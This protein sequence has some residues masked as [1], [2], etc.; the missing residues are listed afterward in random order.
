MTQSFHDLPREERL[1][2]ARRGTSHYSNQLALIDNADFRSPSR[3][4]GWDI[5]TL[6]AHTAYNAS[7]LVN[8]VD[9]ANTGVET[10]MYPSPDARAEQIAYG[11][12]LIPDALRN[13]HDHTLVRLDVAW[14]D[15]SEQAWDN[16][17]KTAQGRTVPMVETLWMR[18]REVWIHAVDL[19]QT[20]TFSDIPRV[21]LDTL[22]PEIVGKWSNTGAGEGL[23]LV[24]S[25]SGERFPVTP[26]AETTEVVGTKTG[27][28]RWATGRGAH[29]V[30]AD[31][32][33]P[34][35]WL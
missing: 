5:A 23:V 35:R 8:L 3:L 7:A 15:S 11:A 12:T 10:P 18:T 2:I 22:V 19:N 29:G 27:L 21:V 13:L 20:A 6:V 24:D 14:R 33:Q 30:N 32:P 9:W 31:A 1:S 16:E 26:G 4:A 17:V 25:E 28:A 34:P